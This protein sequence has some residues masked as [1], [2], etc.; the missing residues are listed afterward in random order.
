MKTQGVFTMKGESVTV[1]PSDDV[2]IIFT[3][4]T[5]EGFTTAR[6]VEIGPDAPTDFKVKQYYDIRTTAVYK[7]KATIRIICAASTKKKEDEDGIQLM[8]WNERTKHW[9]DITKHFNP[10]YNLVIGETSRLSIFGITE[11][12]R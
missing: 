11:R 4:V 9:I 3:D 5:S 12:A 7:G 10:E 8:Q 6:K 2:G 1:F